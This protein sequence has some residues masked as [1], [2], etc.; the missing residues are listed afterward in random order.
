MLPISKE[1]GKGSK[2]LY[3]ALT[4]IYNFFSGAKTPQ[5]CRKKY[6]YTDFSKTVITALCFFVCHRMPTM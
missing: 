5:I 3:E 6:F 2:Y 1:K 4:F